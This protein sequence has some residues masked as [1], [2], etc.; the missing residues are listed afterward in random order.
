MALPRHILQSAAYPRVTHVRTEEH[1]MHV[2][3]LPLEMHPLQ[4]R[5]S[6][7]Y[8]QSRADDTEQWSPIGLTAILY[9]SLGLLPFKVRA[10]QRLPCTLYFTLIVT[11]TGRMIFGP[12]RFSMAITGGHWRL[13]QNC[14]HSYL[15]CLRGL[16]QTYIARLGTTA[17]LVYVGQS[18]QATPSDN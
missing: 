4:A 17:H 3:A 16:W 12:R 6:H 11:P 7:D 1:A 18:G 9:W 8:G 14:K 5:A 10:T 13:I 2:A 15:R